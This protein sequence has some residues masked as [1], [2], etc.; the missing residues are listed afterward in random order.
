MP[1]AL[2]RSIDG[3]MFGAAV[4]G[5]VMLDKHMFVHGGFSMASPPPGAV[6]LRV[7][8]AKDC[9]EIHGEGPPCRFAIGSDRIQRLAPAPASACYL[10]AGMDLRLQAEYP[11]PNLIL[12]FDHAKV[13]D[14]IE[15]GG[16][17]ACGQQRV[18]PCIVNSEIVA[19]GKLAT[20]HL[21]SGAPLNRLFIESIGTAI[22]ALVL[23]LSVGRH[24]KS[25]RSH[26][27][28]LRVARA[29]DFIEAHLGEKIELAEMAAV[30]CLSPYHFLRTFKAITGE[31]PHAYV[32]RRRIG[33][34][35]RLLVS[36][37]LS[38]AEIALATGFS[39]QAHL[40][41]TMRSATGL[42]PAALRRPRLA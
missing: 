9:I 6:E 25:R 11:E 24:A 21:H 22:L 7:Q 27:L 39:S 31:T 18:L 3:N 13:R 40:T 33:E 26:G 4:D 16:R 38:I 14:L 1:G 8:S 23:P 41:T 36:S 34:A 20:T 2:P 15:D 32:V 29:R 42:T 28:D 19:L 30:A 35:E 12:H 5:E 17:V 10:P 37:R